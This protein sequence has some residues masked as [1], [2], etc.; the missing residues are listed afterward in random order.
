MSKGI[1]DGGGKTLKKKRKKWYEPS[2]YI[3]GKGGTVRERER[4][5]ENAFNMNRY[6][7][8]SD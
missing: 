3:R 1:R 4:E 7:T 2:V 5:R 6:T 8:R